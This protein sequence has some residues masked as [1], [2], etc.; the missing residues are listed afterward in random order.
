MV[1]CSGTGSIYKATGRPDIIT[2]TSLLRT[3]LL[4]PGS[5]W[6]ISHYGLIGAAVAQLGVT[7]VVSIVNLYIAQRMLQVKFSEIVGQMRVAFLGSMLMLILVEAFLNLAADMPGLARL[8]VAS[9]LGAL[10]YGLT[11]WALS[12]ETVLMAR[13]LIGFAPHGPK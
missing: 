10:V 2:K 5:W 8:L 11:V 9:T 13:K 7:L 3:T 4:I 6:A 1:R 12:R